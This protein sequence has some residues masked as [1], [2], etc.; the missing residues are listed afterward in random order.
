MVA[1]EGVAAAAEIVVFSIGGEQ[2]IDVVVK[3]LEGEEGSPLVA[4]G[5]VV[6]HNVQIDLHPQLV[7]GENQVFQLGALPVEL[8]AGGVAGV[9]REKADG[10]VAPVVVELLPPRLPVILHLVKL[11]NGHQLD[12]VDPQLLEV[13][14]LLHE[15]GE[16]AG[17]LHAG[18]AVLGEAPDVEFVDH[19]VLHGD[20][21]GLQVAP[22]KVVLHYP[23]LVVLPPG[24]AAAPLALT[25]DGLGVGVQEVLAFVKDFALFRLIGSVYPVGVLKILNVQLEDDHGVDV[26]DAVVLGEGQHGEGRLLLPVKQQQLNGGGPVGVDREIHAAGDGGGPV[27]LIKPGTDGKAVDIV[28]GNQVDG[29]G[30]A[31]FLH[32]QQLLRALGGHGRVALFLH[33]STHSSCYFQWIWVKISAMPSS[34]PSMV[35]RPDSRLCHS[36]SDSGSS[37][38]KITYSMAPAA[39]LRETASSRGFIAPAP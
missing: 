6:E 2:V 35:D 38:P 29:A 36:C 34:M 1:V 8:Q 30:Q 13:G 16:G 22:V 15:S 32:L 7:T 33:K 24:G 4:L 10:A 21:R 25:G 11:K 26:A 37:S 39:K 19:Q 28:Q 18:R 20:K 12:G 14:Q 23:G 3:A 9:G 17:V 31:E 5:G 27:D